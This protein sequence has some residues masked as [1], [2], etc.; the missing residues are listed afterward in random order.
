M[1][2]SKKSDIYPKFKTILQKSS[3][4]SYIQNNLI[5]FVPFK[6]IIKVKTG[7]YAIVYT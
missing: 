3:K 5:L 7:S 2:I 6:N 4:K 1:D